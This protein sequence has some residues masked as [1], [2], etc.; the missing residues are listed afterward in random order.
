MY[1]LKKT[2]VKPAGSRKKGVEKRKKAVS[3]EVIEDFIL[4]HNT[5][6]YLDDSC[7]ENRLADWRACKK[8]FHLLVLCLPDQCSRDNCRRDLFC[9]DGGETR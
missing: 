1:Y 4:P 3:E 6:G 2:V 8:G 5:E 9:L 7:L